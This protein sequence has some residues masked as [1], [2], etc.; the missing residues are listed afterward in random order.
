MADQVIPISEGGDDETLARSALT[1]LLLH[2]EMQFA[3][4]L[5]FDLV[6]APQKNDGAALNFPGGA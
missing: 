5:T 2:R 4:Q 1:Q 3:E 6:L